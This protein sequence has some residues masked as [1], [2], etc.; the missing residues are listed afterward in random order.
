MLDPDRSGTGLFRQLGIGVQQSSE[1]GETTEP[2]INIGTAY[3]ASIPEC[4][5][6]RE[7]DD[8]IREHLLWDPGIT[9]DSEQQSNQ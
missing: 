6:L 8:P 3:Q 7:M 9:C 1:L 5:G 2:M 4:T